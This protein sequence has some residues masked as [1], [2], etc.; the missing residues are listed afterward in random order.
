MDRARR[1]LTTCQ[2]RFHRFAAEFSHDLASHERMADL[3]SVAQ[4]RGRDWANWVKVVRQGLEQSQALVEDGRDALFLCWQ[5]LTERLSTAA[6]PVR[7]IG[8]GQLAKNFDR[9][10][11]KG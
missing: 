10:C 8:I 3:A 9:D 11:V 1:A 6:L 5:E 7:T 2:E 4:E